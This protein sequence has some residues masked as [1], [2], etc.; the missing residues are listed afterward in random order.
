MAQFEVHNSARNVH[1]QLGDNNRMVVHNSMSDMRA[2]DE[3][4]QLLGQI[5]LLSERLDDARSRDLG[6]LA[7]DLDE[8]V[9][10]NGSQK[11]LERTLRRIGSIAQQA[12]DVGAPM[13]E[14]IRK[15][16]EAF[17]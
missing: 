1:Q 7:D 17:G 4:D 9:G 3:F 16:V 10:S 8:D 6:E 11:L 15:L 12:G 14:A 13:I 2:S 5:R